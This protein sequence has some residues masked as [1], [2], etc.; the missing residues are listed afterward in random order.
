MAPTFPAEY[1]VM[2]A[3]LRWARRARRLT[4]AEVGRRLGGL[5]QTFVSKIE[6]GERRLDPIE[7]ARFAA[8]YGTP[9]TWFLE[10]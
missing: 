7:L 4:Q 10:P 8:I 9:L 1:R 3:R 2:L 6:L 5:H